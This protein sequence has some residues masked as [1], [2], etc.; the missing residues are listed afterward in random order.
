MTAF[1][2]LGFIVLIIYSAWISANWVKQKGL[3]VETSEEL[4]VTRGALLKEQENRA[5]EKS[6]YE[7]RLA[8]KQEEILNLKRYILD[9]LDKRNAVD[10]IVMSEDTST[11][12][13]DPS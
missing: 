3:A 11:P 12:D 10:F 4:R 8:A 6:S 13:G 7:S 9:R 1:V 5:V 2:V